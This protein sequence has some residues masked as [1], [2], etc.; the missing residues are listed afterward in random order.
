MDIVEFLTARYDAAEAAIRTG[1]PFT[2]AMAAAWPGLPEGM[3]LG[4]AERRTMAALNA[5]YPYLDAKW[6]LADL[7][8]KRRVIDQA[9][10]YAAKIDGEWGCCHAAAQIRADDCPDIPVDSIEI[11]RELAAVYADHPDYDKVWAVTE[12]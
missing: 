10:Q 8:A 9:F 1:S 3:T 2:D 12:D 5:V 7:A 11:L 4:E 6:A